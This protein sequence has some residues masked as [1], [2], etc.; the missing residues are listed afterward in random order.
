MFSQY[1]D[2]SDFDSLWPDIEAR[3]T[4]ALQQKI[5]EQRKQDTYRFLVNPVQTL[6][7]EQWEKQFRRLIKDFRDERLH[8][9]QTKASVEEEEETDET[10]SSPGRGAIA[11]QRTGS[12]KTRGNDRP[13]VE[14]SDDTDETDDTEEEEEED[15]DDDDDDDDVE[16]ATAQTQTNF[17][18]G[19]AAAESPRKREN[20]TVNKKAEPPKRKL[21]NYPSPG[22][23]SKKNQAHQGRRKKSVEVNGEPTNKSASKDEV[24]DLLNLPP[25]PNDLPEMYCELSCLLAE[26]PGRINWDL[27]ENKASTNLRQLIESK[28]QNDAIAFRTSPFKELVPIGVYDQFTRYRMALRKAFAQPLVT[29]VAVTDR[30]HSG[31]LDAGKKYSVIID[32]LNFMPVPKAPQVVLEPLPRPPE[33]AAIDDAEENGERR[34][35]EGQKDDANGD[36]KEPKKS[37]NEVKPHVRPHGGKKRPINPTASDSVIPTAMKK[38]QQRV[39]LESKPV[40]GPTLERND[41]RNHQFPLS[42]IQLAILTKTTA[43]S[44]SRASLEA[45]P[46]ADPRLERRPPTIAGNPTANDSDEDDGEEPKKSSNGVETHGWPLGK[47]RLRK[48]QMSTSNLTPSEPH[49]DNSDEEPVLKK[50]ALSKIRPQVGGEELKKPPPTAKAKIDDPDS[51]EKEE[52]KKEVSKEGDTISTRPDESFFSETAEKTVT[53][54]TKSAPAAKKPPDGKGRDKALRDSDKPDSA[55]QSKEEREETKEE[56]MPDVEEEP[57]QKADDEEKNV[58]NHQDDHDKEQSEKHRGGDDDA[59]EVL[60]YKEDDDGDSKEDEVEQDEDEDYKEDVV[61]HEDSEGDDSEVKDTQAQRILSHSDWS[62]DEMD[63][64]PS[65]ML[66]PVLHELAELMGKEKHPFDWEEIENRASKKLKA[67]FA[68]KRQTFPAFDKN[69]GGYLVRTYQRKNFRRLRSEIIKRLNGTQIVPSS[70]LKFRRQKKVSVVNKMIVPDDVDESALTDEQRELAR[71]LA[72]QEPD[73]ATNWSLI[74]SEATPALKGLIE[75]KKVHAD[76]E[77]EPLRYLVGV[78]KYN[79]FK[80]VRTSLPGKGASDEEDVPDLSSVPG[81]E[82]WTPLQLEFA[83]ILAEICFL[84]R[85]EGRLSGNESFDWQYIF[86]RA[87]PALRKLMDQK[88]AE[89]SSFFRLPIRFLVSNDP[90]VQTDFLQLRNDIEEKIDRAKAIAQ[91]KAVAPRPKKGLRLSPEQVEE[92][93]FPRM[94]V[95]LAELLED[96]KEQHPDHHYDTVYDWDYIYSVASE[97]L[98]QH[99]KKKRA[100]K[101]FERTKMNTLIGRERQEGM[102]LLRLKIRRFRGQR[103]ASCGSGMRSAWEQAR[104]ATSNE[105]PSITISSPGVATDVMADMEPYIPDLTVL[106]EPE[107]QLA[108]ILEDIKFLRPD[109]QLQTIWDMEYIMSHAPGRLRRHIHRKMNNF[110]NW[111]HDKLKAF[112]KNGHREEFDKM[113]Q[114]VKSLLQRGKIQPL[115]AQLVELSKYAPKKKIY[116]PKNSRPS[117]PTTSAR[118]SPLTSA[119]GK[120][121]TIARGMP[122]KVS[123]DDDEDGISS[124]KRLEVEDDDYSDTDA[125]FTDE[126]EMITLGSSTRQIKITTTVKELAISWELFNKDGPTGRPDW[127]VLIDHVSRPL[128]QLIRE[129]RKLRSF[130]DDPTLLLVPPD[131]RGSFE[132]LRSEVRRDRTTYTTQL[133]KKVKLGTKK[134][135]PG[136]KRPREEVEEEPEEEV[137]EDDVQVDDDED[138]NVATIDDGPPSM[139]EDDALSRDQME[140]LAELM[141][142]ATRKGKSW[143]YIESRA[144]SD[145]KLIMAEAAKQPDYLDAPARCLVPSHLWSDF[146]KLRERVSKARYKDDDDSDYDEEKTDAWE[147]VEKQS[148]RLQ[149]FSKQMRQNLLDF[150]AEHETMLSWRRDR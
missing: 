52:D 45:I 12:K 66:E 105:D 129:K 35:D 36:E 67:L 62:D 16:I 46:K 55:D 23:T 24:F 149:A 120:A 29:L 118:I 10:D 60:K 121:S 69:R 72:K 86:A 15:D 117:S 144:S 33:P 14:I 122:K 106:I 109:S 135:K 128:R 4:S 142:K 85:K 137:T 81:V 93:E 150:E 101:A 87:S 77:K 131:L 63:T 2:G 98:L 53:P 41:V 73:K 82:N 51:D 84:G 145:L 59:E 127:D 138:D 110:K 134:T 103:R 136:R 38:S 70:T 48:P 64:R 56:D 90:Q 7:A 114:K 28:R 3:A 13:Q 80:K 113:R 88:S 32:K 68:A 26:V 124:Q 130:N 44:Q 119:S 57:K 126:E 19:T 22:K 40:S 140:E 139:L 116:K 54:Q 102:N 49:E 111:H 100:M 89:Y 74:E 30:L 21:A 75:R 31:R 83:R 20:H 78:N 50:R 148:Q 115:P 141:T 76:F 132:K 107:I 71:L 123:T 5:A 34:V 143:T 43:K 94:F 6:V 125:S 1:D 91:L 61:E 92:F 95:E 146:T 65:K 147:I 25:A 17:R 99:I 18:S 42:T 9:I 133:P 97:R 47:K 8:K 112:L 11:R 37:N 39:S 79:L 108:R 104:Y 58:A 27:L 96:I